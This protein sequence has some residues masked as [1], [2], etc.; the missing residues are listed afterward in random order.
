MK[1]KTIRHIKENGCRYDIQID[2]NS[3]YYANGILIHNTD[4]QQISFTW[5]NG[6][7]LF[8]RNKSHIKNK[9]QNAMTISEL[10][11]KFSGRDA[12][13]TAFNIAAV[14]LSNAIK[15]LS[16]KQKDKIFKNGKKLVSCEVIYTENEN[17]I[18]Y[19]A[20]EIRFHGTKEYNL[21][22]KEID[23]NKKDGR[24]LAGMLKQVKQDKQSTYQIKN[25]QNV[26]LPEI[27]DFESQTSNFTSD[28]D[29]IM[30][31]YK[32]SDN[33]TINDYQRKYFI[34]LA[35]SKNINYNQE[36]I[37]R[38]ATGNKSYSMK[39]IKKDFSEEQLN[40]IKEIEDNISEYYQKS[41]EPIENI[42]LKLGVTVLKNMTNI[43]SLHPD[44]SNRKVAKKIENSISKIKE[45]GN[46]ELKAKLNKEL[47]RMEAAG[48]FESIVPTEG[49]TFMW[50]GKFMKLTGSFSPQDKIVNMVNK[51]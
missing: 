17:L 42:I 48:G 4:G 30:K 31:K 37:D 33:D 22:G 27:P 20:N 6:Q 28:L 18:S 47:K 45:K 9:A 13:E 2:N 39:E 49:I 11:K 38:W 26:N 7:L 34:N 5:K 51:L 10:S 50:K 44:K 40:K 21:E 1:I 46:E 24:I 8:A 23:S 3:C 16:D 15:N 25:L 14:D 35:E 19:G 43:M 41:I 12:L 32:L 36:L 29:K